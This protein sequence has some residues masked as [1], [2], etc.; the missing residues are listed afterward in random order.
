MTQISTLE[1]RASPIDTVQCDASPFDAW[2]DAAR[3]LVQAGVA[4]ERAVWTPLG[5][6]SVDAPADDAL[7]VRT[8][9]GYLDLA[10]SAVLHADPARFALLYRLLWRLQ[11]APRLMEA[12]ADAD[13][14]AIDALARDVRRDIYRMRAFVRFRLADG[15]HHVAW[16]EPEHHILDANAAFFV[17][18]FGAL[19]WSILTPLGT[20]HWDGTLLRKGPPADR[21]DLP[22]GDPVAA[23]WRTYRAGMRDPRAPEPVRHTGDCAALAQRLS[24]G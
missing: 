19:R 16:F 21:A 3:R 2:R 17:R 11:S 12:R 1:K 23:Q 8:S 18:R 24:G 6:A 22:A 7:P 5:E 10:Q 15:G 14:R 13:V 20:L 4:P 9:R